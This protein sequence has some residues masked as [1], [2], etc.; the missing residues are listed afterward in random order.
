MLSAAD[1]LNHLREVA[2]TGGLPA[3]APVVHA[4]VLPS[5]H[6]DAE[7][8][9]KKDQRRERKELRAALK[10][11]QLGPTD[12]GTTLTPRRTRRVGTGART[13]A[14][15]APEGSNGA[16]PRADGGGRLIRNR[17]RARDGGNRPPP[18]GCRPTSRP[19][20]T[21]PRPSTRRC[22]A[23]RRLPRRPPRKRPPTP[24]TGRSRGDRRARQEG[25]VLRLDLVAS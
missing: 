17:S 18:R 16:G 3:P 11:V 1:Q 14:A 4:P 8:V 6:A 5:P 23:T 22:S 13:G 9:S 25:R 15:P 12:A 2:I 24:S 20:P 19:R 21:S 10:A 7:N